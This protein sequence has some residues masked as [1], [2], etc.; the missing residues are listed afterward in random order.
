MIRS[1]QQ[2]WMHIDVNA[3]VKICDPY[4]DYTSQA[5]YLKT[6]VLSEPNKSG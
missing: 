4:L 5:G 2:I 1:H 3:R 6:S